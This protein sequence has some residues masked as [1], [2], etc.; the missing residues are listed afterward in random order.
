LED[1]VTIH[2]DGDRRRKSRS[3]SGGDWFTLKCV[4]FEVFMGCQSEGVYYI[5][6]DLE[7]ERERER[8]RESYTGVIRIN[9]T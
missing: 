9:E 1:R 6:K 3:W 4:E 2:Q 5:N 8:E 7:R